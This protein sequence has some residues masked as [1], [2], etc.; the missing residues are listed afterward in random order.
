[1]RHVNRSAMLTLLVFVG[2]IGSLARAAEEPAEGEAAAAE[3]E[4]A[5]EPVM[6]ASIAEAV[7]AKDSA[8]SE[9][10]LAKLLV[11][12][13]FEP[14]EPG[15][16]G[17]SAAAPGKGRGGSANWPKVYKKTAG[18]VVFLVGPGSSGTG[19]L[20]DRAG[21]LITNYHVAD[22]SEVDDKRR[23]TMHA[24]LGT[25]DKRGRM[26]AA[27]EPL[28]AVLY[29]HDEIRDLALMKIED[30]DQWDGK[31]VTVSLDDS[32]KSQ[33]T[34]GMEVAGIGNGA[35]GLR[36]SMKPG[37]I[38]AVGPQTDMSDLLA[39][40]DIHRRNLGWE[41]TDSELDDLKDRIQAHYV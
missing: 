30:I 27:E 17:E 10:G 28:T 24:Y 35:V 14:G 19:F 31:P 3:G 5:A 6:P 33:P 15:A 23:R 40:L 8:W 1:M 20:I 22:D 16:P 41:L 38:T 32:R 36:W 29:A 12:G 39:Q 11:D 25:Q 4:E 2:S 9:A 34:S 37:H 18:A 26:V 13:A 7:V 21:W